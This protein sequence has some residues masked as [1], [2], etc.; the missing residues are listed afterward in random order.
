MNELRKGLVLVLKRTGDEMRLQFIVISL[1][2]I[3]H[4]K[5]LSYN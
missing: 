3:Y 5:S 1:T 2:D 4:I